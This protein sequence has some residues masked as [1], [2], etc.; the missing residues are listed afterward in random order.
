MQSGWA[1]A[2]SACVATGQAVVTGRQSRDCYPGGVTC[3]LH[4]LFDFC[5][6]HPKKGIGFSEVTKRHQKD[7]HRLL[8]GQ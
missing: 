2:H 4:P 3:G 8:S 7:S 5:I 1:A 6:L